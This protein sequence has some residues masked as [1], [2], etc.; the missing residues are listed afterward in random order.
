MFKGLLVIG[1]FSIAALPVAAQDFPRFEAGGGYSYL[2]VNVK[3]TNAE[4]VPPSSVSESFNL[5]GGGGNFV[6]NATKN[7][8]L[9]ADLSGYKVTG[10]P[11][12]VSAN[13]FTYLFGP[14]F[15]YRGSEK[16]Q[17]FVHA[18]F[19]GAY[20]SG[21]ASGAILN[22]AIQPAQITTTFNFSGNTNAFA[23]ALGGGV[24]YKVAH[25]ISLRL[26][27]M[28]YLMTRFD[29]NINSSGNASAATQ[30]NF[31]VGAGVQFTF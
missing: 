24:D 22:G 2:R 15:T 1:L 28:D 17:P 5:Q 9:V 21:S 12:G 26:V 3:A 27:Q 30:N 20:A 10:L 25:H 6:F 16:V 19:G 7:F 4:L 29:T 18:L 14:R 23:M 31:R 8:G 13:V 11:S